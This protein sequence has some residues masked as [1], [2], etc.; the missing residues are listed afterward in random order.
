[1]RDLC[2]KLVPSVALGF[3][4]AVLAATATRLIAQP[5]PPAVT[6]PASKPASAIFVPWVIKDDPTYSGMDI[7]R[8]VM[9]KGWTLKGGVIWT[10]EDAFP[11]Q[12][13][14]HW[15]DA[16][17]LCAMD[18]YPDVYCYWDVRMARFPQAPNS[19]H[20][21]M[22]IARPPADQF[23]AIMNYV[24]PRFR[25]DLQQARVVEKIKKPE[26]SK[27]AVDSTPKLPNLNYGAY[28]GIITF[29]YQKNGETVK[30]QIGLVFKQITSRQLGYDQWSLENITSARGPES[31]REQIKTWRAL[32]IESVKPNMVWI[33][34][35]DQF[36]LARQK[37]SLEVLKDQ[38]KRAQMFSNMVTK[39]INDESNHQ[40]NQ[41]MSDSDRNSERQSDLTRGV[42][43]WKTTDGGMVKLPTQYGQ[44]WQGSNGEIHMNN[45]PLF[46]PNTDPNMNQ[47]TWTRI[48]QAPQ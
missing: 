27:K 12:F 37:M 42:S 22:L 9:P 29:E 31:M 32:M 33:D 28:S 8:G 24:L 5:A 26:W 19:R 4:A 15:G 10:L 14:L 3:L 16:Q 20:L 48:E 23:D 7:S 11:A 38:A 35:R 43:P 39:N 34:K 21:G 30:E 40:F 17:D 13:R 2:H 25:P 47:A 41:Y 18:D 36:V 44:A 45:D 46:D 1:M 6:Q